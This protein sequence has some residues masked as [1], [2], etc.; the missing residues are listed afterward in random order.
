MKY[1]IYCGDKQY[2]I[3]NVKLNGYGDVVKAP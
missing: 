1:K 2:K 3:P